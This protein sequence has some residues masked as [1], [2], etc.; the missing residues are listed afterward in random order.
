MFL[1]P[2]KPVSRARAQEEVAHPV[3]AAPVQRPIVA[4]PVP[5]AGALTHSGVFSSLHCITASVPVAASSAIAVS[6]VQAATVTAAPTALQPFLPFGLR[7]LF[8]RAYI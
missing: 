5:D 2:S 8:A 3:A 6:V 4:G 7:H 1:R